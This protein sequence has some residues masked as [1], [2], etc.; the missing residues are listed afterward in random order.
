MNP[1]PTPARA[2]GD[3]PETLRATT[4]RRNSSTAAA[5]EKIKNYIRDHDLEIGDILPTENQLVELLGFSRSTI[6]EAVRI[7]ETL[8][9]VE[10]RHGYGTR[11]ATMSLEPL[12]QGLVFR[13]T[14]SV[15]HSRRRLID[16]VDTREALDISLGPTLVASPNPKALAQMQAAVTEMTERSARGE[17]FLA[18][19]L[20]FHRAL[21]SQIHN[22]VVTDLIEALWH[23][24][25]EVMPILEMDLDSAPHIQHTISAHQ[26]L[27]D[28]IVAGDSAAYEQ[29]VHRHYRPLREMLAA[30]ADH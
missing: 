22:P 3:Q 14:Q 11:V 27:I 17:S 7:L 24:H 28:A 23:V 13:V 16:V 20:S 18:A 26:D 4:T 5:V 12:V 1:A 8:D 6:R 9:I 19:D 29:A 25:M 15:K 10:V 2:P 21:L 30:S